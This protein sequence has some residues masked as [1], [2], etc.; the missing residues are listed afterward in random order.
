M[1][2]ADEN[3]GG[4]GQQYVY[5]IYLWIYEMRVQSTEARQ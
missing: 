1:P 5:S 4:E 3:E 2:A